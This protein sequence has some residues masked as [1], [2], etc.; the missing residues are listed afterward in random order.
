[1]KGR[2]RRSLLEALNL[3]QKSKRGNLQVVN[4]GN[5][6]ETQPKAF[7]PITVTLAQNAKHFQPAYHMFSIDALSCQSP[8]G[9][10]SPPASGGV[11]CSS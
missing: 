9:F 1:M 10:F 5:Q 4:S 3:L 6:I 11:A 2:Q 7:S 8:I